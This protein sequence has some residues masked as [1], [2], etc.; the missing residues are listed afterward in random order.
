VLMQNQPVS[1]AANVPK[2]QAE[3]AYPPYAP[4][5]DLYGSAYRYAPHPANFGARTIALLLD[6]VI[7]G[8]IGAIVIVVLAGFALLAGYLTGREEGAALFGIGAYWLALPAAALV[9]LVYY[10]KSETGVHQAT[11]GKR[12]L[13]IRVVT[14]QGRTISAGQC[15]G[16]LLCKS[17]LSGLLLGIGC[18]MALFTDKRQCL[19]D[20]L[21]GTLVVDR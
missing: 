21:D 13:G 10:I 12:I 20:L 14:M 6:G 17:I 15:I 19:H 7:L 11:L 1:P 16:R 9:A 5:P 4:Q 3:A 18:W 8:V 2:S